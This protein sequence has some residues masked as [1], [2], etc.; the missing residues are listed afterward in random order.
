MGL[1][2][3]PTTPKNLSRQQK[4]RGQLGSSNVFGWRLEQWQYEV[5]SGGRIWCCPD[6]SRRITWVVA[7]ELPINDSVYRAKIDLSVQ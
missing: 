5:T 6:P 7:A 1:T 3:R 4:L 2:E